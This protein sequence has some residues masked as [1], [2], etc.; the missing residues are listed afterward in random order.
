MALAGV[1]LLGAGSPAL[2]TTPAAVDLGAAAHFAVLAGSGISDTGP[3]VI[4][5]DVGTH[6]VAA[7]SG[8][9]DKEASGSVDRAGAKSQQAQRDL[10]NAFAS[11]AVLPRDGTVSLADVRSLP[12][13]VYDV[14]DTKQGFAANLTLDG[15]NAPNPVWIFVVAKNLVTAPGSTITLVN[16]AQACNV[17]WRVG[18][19]ATLGSESTF[20]GSILAMTSVSVGSHVTIAG[21]LLARTGAV[22]LSGDRITAPACTLSIANSAPQ[23]AAV[24]ALPPT[25]RTT[26]A[27]A[28]SQPALPGYLPIV[29]LVL[30]AAAILLGEPRQRHRRAASGGW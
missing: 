24:A 6:P 21:R 18:G 26:D 14:A 17:F 30:L 19:S 25:S 28:G 1:I 11:V 12:P 22:S 15:Q 13:G 8:R 2:W 29:I 10:A 27:A 3:S 16:G 4:S 9:L 5:G 7:I 23:P 20:A